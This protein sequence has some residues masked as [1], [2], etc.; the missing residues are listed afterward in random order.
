MF[1]SQQGKT[2]MPTK[3]I[4]FLLFYVVI[5]M[6]NA[7]Y[8]TFMPVY[9]NN[10]KFSQEQ[11]GLLLSLGPLI[12]MIG[13]PVWGAF[14]DRAK[15]KNQVLRVLL[16]GSGISILF[17]PLSHEFFY[18]LMFICIF[19]FFQTSIFALS[20]AI[21]LEELDRHPT[22][23]FGWIR[24]GGT[25]G[26]A[27]MSLLFGFI[28]KSYIGSM[29]PVYACTMV[30]GLFCLW[31]FPAAAGRPANVM[32]RKFRELFKNGK[33]MFYL[34]INFI[35]QITLGYYYAFFPIYFKEMGGD[36]VMLGWSMAISSL[37]ELPFLL[38]S[39][40]IFKRVPV[41]VIL[42]VAALASA[43]RWFLFSE[44]EVAY[45]IL[46]VQVLHGLIFIVLS[47]TLATIINREVPP[48]WKASGQTLNGLLSLGAARIIGSFVGGIMSAAYGMRQVFLYSSWV[49][50]ACVVVFG[51][52]IYYRRKQH[53]LGT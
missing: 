15:S 35:I 52:V 24:L 28:A 8:G 44:I 47:V 25:I 22:W 20:D 18:I 26:F 42:L 51:A 10:A 6:G 16:I 14:G 37:S 38:F 27:L 41:S 34:S 9:L 12:A 7:V 19:T 1:N 30:A 17:F 23:S 50:M 49:S 33:L 46:P 43:F 3:L 13:Q 4:A 5:Y 2:G 48:E 32:G 29:F 53:E 45:W 36:S 31:R 11:I 39:G 40:I 21:T